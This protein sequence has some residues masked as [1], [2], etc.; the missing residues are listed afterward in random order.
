MMCKIW[1]FND[2]LIASVSEEVIAF[3]V[4][5]VSGYRTRSNDIDVYEIDQSGR[6]NIKQESGQTFVLHLY[7]GYKLELKGIDA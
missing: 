5:E 4:K 3:V 2:I 6:L 1:D 7:E